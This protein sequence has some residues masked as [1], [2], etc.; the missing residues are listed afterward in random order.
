MSTSSK[1]YVR[2]IASFIEEANRFL[3][4]LHLLQP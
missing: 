2:V 1:D 3:R 4:K